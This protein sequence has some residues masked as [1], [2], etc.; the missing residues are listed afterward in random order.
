M[1]VGVFL[2]SIWQAGNW[3]RVS[4]PSTHHFSTHII[5]TDWHQDLVL[6]AVLG[7]VNSKFVGKYQ[8]NIDLIKVLQI[9]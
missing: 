9:C 8:S 7:L 4:V 5:A 2:V 1:V 6:Y 3:L